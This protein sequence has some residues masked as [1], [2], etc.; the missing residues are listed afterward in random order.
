MIYIQQMHVYFKLKELQRKSD[1]NLYEEVIYAGIKTIF[2][3]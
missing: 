2:F 1:L 3:V